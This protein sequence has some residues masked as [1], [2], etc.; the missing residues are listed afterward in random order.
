VIANAIIKSTSEN[1]PC[2][3]NGGATRV[4]QIRDNVLSFDEQ[5]PPFQYP[6]VATDTPETI[7]SFLA[8]QIKANEVVAA[9]GRP[10]FH[11]LVLYFQIKVIVGLLDLLLLDQKHGLLNRDLLPC[12]KEGEAFAIVFQASNRACSMSVPPPRI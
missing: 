6:V 2:I 11:C 8:A 1:R 12:A 5:P 10:P 3:G 9:A 4:A 7:A